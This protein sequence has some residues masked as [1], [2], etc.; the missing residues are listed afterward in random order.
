MPEGSVQRDRPEIFPAV[1]KT[2]ESVERPIGAWERFWDNG[3]ARKVVLLVA[4]VAAWESYGRWVS[5]S[6]LFPTFFQTATALIRS[7]GSGDFPINAWNTIRLLLKG[8][9]AGLALAAVLTAFASVSR[10]GAD[11]LETLA[12]MFNPLPSV[13][14][15]PFAMI[16][17]GFSDNA[18]IFVLIH[19]VVWSVALNT[20]AGFRAVSPTLRMV[21]HNYGLSAPSF[22][23]RILI[24]GAF[25]SILAGLKI[26]WA[27]SWRTLLAA[28]LVFGASGKSG[29]IGGY[30]NKNQQNGR[31]NDV[32]AALLAVILFGLAIDFVFKA[33]ERRTVRR[34]GMET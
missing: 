13:A 14:L 1:S 28:E 3:A 23:L 25:P 15:L 33:I 32:F 20:Q 7:I 17:F 31:T 24:P 12:S 5:D 34:W 30:I 27:F 10:V 9:G 26:G 21:G 11:L 8:Y 4:L 16:T 2:F 19:A 22:I 6:D 18:V 29:G